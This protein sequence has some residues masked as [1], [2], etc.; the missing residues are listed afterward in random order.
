MPTQDD[1]LHAAS[2]CSGCANIAGAKMAGD[3]SFSLSLSPDDLEANIW[4][5]LTPPGCGVRRVL[6]G[7]AAAFNAVTG[8]VIIYFQ[9]PQL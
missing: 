7:T 9:Q 6:E 4:R 1:A 8:R 2:N 3:L 5:V